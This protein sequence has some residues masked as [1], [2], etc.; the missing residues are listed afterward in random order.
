MP[1]PVYADEDY[2]RGQRNCEKNSK[3][4]HLFHRRLLSSQVKIGALPLF[5]AHRSSFIF[6]LSLKNGVAPAMTN[7][8]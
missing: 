6:H 1:Q 3:T 2:G 8:R 7:E 5:I 4:L